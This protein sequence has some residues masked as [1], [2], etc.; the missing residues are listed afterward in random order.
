M[1]TAADGSSPAPSKV[2]V[3]FARVRG[4][5]SCC[6]RAPSHGF[7][8]RARLIFPIVLAVVPLAV[9]VVQIAS[10]WRAHELADAET[11]ALQFSR[12]LAAVHEA[13]MRQAQVALDAVAAAIG[14]TGSSD[15]VTTI[16]HSAVEH[17]TLYSNVGVA[18]ANGQI[19]A[20]HAPLPPD[21]AAT[22][23]RLV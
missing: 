3:G 14:G 6:M 16:L 13:S 2:S 21:L 8:F 15:S 18:I 11:A 22:I 10:A 1:N 7:T 9:I 23:H 19:A 20:S 12:H 17:G 4:S 5:W